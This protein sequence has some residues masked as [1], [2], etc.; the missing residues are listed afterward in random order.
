MI[1]RGGLFYFGLVYFAWH[2]V[3]SFGRAEF[4]GGF[5][6]PFYFLGGLNSVAALKSEKRSREGLW[7]GEKSILMWCA[8]RVWEMGLAPGSTAVSP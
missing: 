4:L 3:F 2:V 8:V 7:G 1:R 5:I 6:L